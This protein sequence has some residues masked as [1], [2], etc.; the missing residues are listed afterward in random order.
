MKTK[1]KDPL[2]IPPAVGSVSIDPAIPEPRPTFWQRLFKKPEN[3]FVKLVIQQA[4]LTHA[5]MCD[6][7]SY[8]DNQTQATAAQLTAH[9]KAADEVRRILINELNDTFITPFD[10]EDI[11]TLSR[12]ID[13]VLDYAYSTVTE[14]E[15]FKVKPTHYMQTMGN[16]LRDASNELL[17]AVMR[18][19]QHGGVASD[20]V[21]RA[22]G[23]ENKIEETYRLALADLFADINDVKQVVKVMKLREVYRH[24]SN[25]GDRVDEAANAIADIVVKT[26]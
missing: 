10:R 14:M 26:M 4:T 9:E 15:L 25:A 21:R 8:M 23:M 22:K 24:L 3:V 7:T 12:A 5:G 19:E 17:L 20:H 2:P 16:L 1:K 11:F 18:L 13:D 6:L